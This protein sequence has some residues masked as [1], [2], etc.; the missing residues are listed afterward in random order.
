MADVL[1]AGS[2]NV[3]VPQLADAF[4]EGMRRFVAFAACLPP[5]IATSCITY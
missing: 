3:E 4:A 2:T 1:P 5:S